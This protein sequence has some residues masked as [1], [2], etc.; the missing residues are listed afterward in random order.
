VN[1]R[2]KLFIWSTVAAM[3]ALQ[4]L[5]AL[6]DSI[7]ETDARVDGLRGFVPA[8]DVATLRDLEKLRADLTPTANE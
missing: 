6:A 8:D 7:E 4:A 5:E 2:L 1:W 3:A